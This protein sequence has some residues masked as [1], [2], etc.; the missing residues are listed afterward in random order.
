[1]LTL[2]SPSEVCAHWLGILKSVGPGAVVC[3][4]NPTQEA[5]DWEG[6]SSRSAQAK[7]CEIPSHPSFAGSINRRVTVQAGPGMK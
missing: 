5:R 1:M 2:S 6:H 3:T 4:Y 7:A